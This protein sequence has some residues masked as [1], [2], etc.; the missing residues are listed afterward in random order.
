MQN[1]SSHSLSPASSQSSASGSH[2]L[3][4][5]TTEGMDISAGEA[6]ALMGEEALAKIWNRPG[7]EEVL[8]VSTLV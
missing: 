8:F 4:F 7:A 5:V 2:T 6:A 1:D 3:T